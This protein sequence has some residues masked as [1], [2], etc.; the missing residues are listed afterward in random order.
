MEPRKW[1][2]TKYI[3]L[4][5]YLKATLKRIPIKVHI[6]YLIIPTNKSTE[7]TIIILKQDKS[8]HI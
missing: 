7:V 8:Y 5:N 6:F 1:M 4:Y 2:P 3:S